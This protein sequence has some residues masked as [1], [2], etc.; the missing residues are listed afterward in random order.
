M[1][2]PRFRLSLGVFCLALACPSLYAGD[3]APREG[4]AAAL[5]ARIDQFIE[6]GCRDH[7]VTP[8][9]L[10]DDAE[11]LRR[12]SLD[13]TG[14]IPAGMDVR[15]FLADKSPDK[16]AKKIDDLLKGPLYVTHF[17]NVWRSLLIPT[18]NNPQVQFLATQL[19]PWLR[20]HL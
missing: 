12:L 19:D 14:R 2:N 1:A 3:E 9:P 7:K 11:F 13:L 20:Q 16:R 5:A 6:A 8:A 15:D 10:A 17:T 18:G 4:D